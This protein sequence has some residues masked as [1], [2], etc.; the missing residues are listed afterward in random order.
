MAHYDPY[1]WEIAVEPE[2][3]EEILVD[4]DILE[5]AT[6]Q[7]QRQQAKDEA[8]AL[9]KEL[10][11]TRLTDKQRQ[12]VELYFYEG[13]T[14]AQIA[15]KLNINQQVVSKHLFGAIRNG[16]RVGGAMR[17]LRKLCEKQGID[18]KKW[19]TGTHY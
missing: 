3:L 17:K 6:D 8:I 15:E 2:I 12:I 1:F 18:P 7:Q 5:D 10:I 16:Q 13:Q 9:I 4:T 19:M 11:T 14:Q